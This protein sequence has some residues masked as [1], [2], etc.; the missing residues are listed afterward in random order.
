[1]KMRWR[2]T[3]IKD[4]SLRGL[5]G[6]E[7]RQKFDFWQ[8]Q[9]VKIFA[10]SSKIL[11]PRSDRAKFREPVP[12]PDF[13]SYPIGNRCNLIISVMAAWPIKFT[14]GSKSGKKHPLP[15]DLSTEKFT[16][17]RKEQKFLPICLRRLTLLT[18]IKDPSLRGLGGNEDRQKF[19]FWQPQAVKIFDKKAKRL[20]YEKDRRP[21]RSFNRKWKDKM[22]KQMTTWYQN[23]H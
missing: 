23:N 10:G 14:E 21:G 18:I 11:P 17:N 12:I 22:N 5:G 3:I 1:M 20:A 15:I 8:P 4:P 16:I 6:N 13:I 7:D 9:A 19:D 2:S